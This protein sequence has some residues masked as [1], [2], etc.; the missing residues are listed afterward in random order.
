MG[1]IGWATKVKAKAVPLKIMIKRMKLTKKKAKIKI[2]RKN[3][4]NYLSYE[5]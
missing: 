2:L 4:F 3:K 1:D 5:S